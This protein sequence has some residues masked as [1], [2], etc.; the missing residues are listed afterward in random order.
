[1]LYY[2]RV[3]TRPLGDLWIINIINQLKMNLILSIITKIPFVLTADQS[4]D[5]G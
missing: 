2:V 4:R 1:M 3:A 5:I